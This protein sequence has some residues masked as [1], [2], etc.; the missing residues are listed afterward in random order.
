MTFDPNATRSRSDHRPPRHG[1]PR[2]V[3]VG[4]GGIGLVLLIAYMLLGGNPN[5][6]GP[7]HAGRGAGRGPEKLGARPPTARPEQDANASDDCRILGYVNS[8]QA[9]WTGNFSRLRKAI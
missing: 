4:G 7:L 9:Y 5:D 6:L 3:A 1:R 2:R 8:V